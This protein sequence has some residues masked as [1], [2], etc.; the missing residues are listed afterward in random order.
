MRAC[1]DG[2][3]AANRLTWGRRCREI[4]AWVFPS[5]VLVLMPKCPAC[6]AGYVAVWTGLGLSLTAATYVRWVLLILCA[7]SLLYLAI[8]WMGQLLVLFRSPTTNFD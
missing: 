4:T 1:C 2:Q 3:N 6:L 8:K 5:A 7:V